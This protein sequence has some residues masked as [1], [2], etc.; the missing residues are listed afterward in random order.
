MMCLPDFLSKYSHSNLSLA[1]S[2]LFEGKGGRKTI[3]CTGNTSKYANNLKTFRL[4]TKACLQLKAEEWVNV[5]NN[6]FIKASEETNIRKFYLDSQNY[7][8]L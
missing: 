2:P 3:V 1:L 7:C 6:C 8:A 4:D 5:Y